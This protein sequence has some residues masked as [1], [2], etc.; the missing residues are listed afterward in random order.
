[1]E[2]VMVDETGHPLP[3]YMVLL[4]DIHHH[5]H[6][7]HQHLFGRHHLILFVDYYMWKDQN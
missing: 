7:H 1:V 6:H 3:S 2:I 5:Y 4:W